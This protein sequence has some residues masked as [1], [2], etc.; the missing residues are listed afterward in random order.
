MKKRVFVEKENLM[1]MAYVGWQNKR[2]ALYGIKEGYKLAADDLVDIALEKGEENRIDILDQYIFPIMYCYR[3]SIEISLKLIYD[4][5]YNKLPDNECGGHDL[6]KI[7]DNKIIKEVIK[8][9]KL[10]HIK[11]SELDEIRSL[12]KELQGFDSKGDVW[13][14]L[15]NT[16]GNLYYTK[17]KF[18]DYISLKKNI[19]YLYNQ[20]DGMYLMI[21]AQINS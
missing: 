1:E 4:R 3:H 17:W 9:L 21:N 13:R 18:I 16:K 8:D 19:N 11:K 7:W 15:M 12:L 5:T 10:V 20:L 14:Y 6:L 2:L